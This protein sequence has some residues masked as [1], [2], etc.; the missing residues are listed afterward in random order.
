MVLDIEMPLAVFSS[1]FL[2]ISA[3]ISI[4]PRALHGQLFHFPCPSMFS[5]DFYDNY[6]RP[7]NTEFRTKTFNIKSSILNI[8]IRIYNHECFTLDFRTRIFETVLPG[9]DF[10]FESSIF[11]MSISKL[12]VHVHG[13]SFSC[14]VLTFLY[15]L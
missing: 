11:S 14:N 10:N 5:V 8:R 6:G 13:L 4:S 2:L 12:T 7:L 1:F 9:L 3:Y 15:T